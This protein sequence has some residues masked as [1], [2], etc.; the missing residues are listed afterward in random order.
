[1]RAIHAFLVLSAFAA[2]AAQA[3]NLNLKGD[4]VLPLTRDELR[5]C[6]D[7]E[8]GINER[9]SKLDAQLRELDAESVGI[10]KA[11][12]ALSDELRTVDASDPL[13][14]DAYNVKSRAHDGRVNAY[15]KR[16]DA[17]N[18]QVKA[19]NKE[20]ADW[21]ARCATRTFKHSDKESILKERKR[22][23]TQSDA[24]MPRG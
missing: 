21:M 9:G 1:M 17:H 10:S 7:W 12:Q 3:Q 16:T 23:T 18:E 5:S 11:A 2:G 20:H 24:A 13:A 19:Q 14:V 22:Q 4:K 15:N 8:D 6:M